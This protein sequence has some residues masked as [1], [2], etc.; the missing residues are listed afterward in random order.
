MANLMGGKKVDAALVGLQRAATADDVWKACVKLMRAA[1]PVYHVLLG[2]PSLGIMPMF[3]RATLAIPDVKRFAEL[4]PLNDVIREQPLTPVSRMSDHFLPD[5]PNWGAFMEECVKPMG[6][7]HAAA[8]LFWN[9]DGVFLGQL[10]LIRTEAQGDFSDA[11]MDLLR[12]LHPHVEAVVHRLLA[13]EER[14]AAH[15]SLEYA[16]GALPLPI[17]VVGWEGGLNFSNA[18]ALDAMSA[19]QSAGSKTARALK[20]TWTLPAEIQAGCEN[21]KRGWE[22]AVLNHDFNGLP[23]NF[24]LT[25]PSVSGF[26]AEIQLVESKAGRALQPSF[27]IHF[28]LPP[29]ENSETA[30][31][32]ARLS[33]LTHAEHEI[34]RLAAA[35]DD[36]AD[37]ARELGIS[38][39][40]VRTH[41]RNVFRKLGITSRSRLVP[42]Y[43]AIK[44]KPG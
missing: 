23:R 26:R 38:L 17:V 12:E 27:A 9:A 30:R 37:I 25:H 39:S 44:Q 18:A 2:L 5:N 14:F 20:P 19:W 4:A 32:L 41:L 24:S 7:R 21:L 33:K 1:M 11:E 8:L 13:L 3:M 29:A 16:I 31:A 40:T 28:Q 42:L 15:L 34:V 43:Q 36:N 22:Q 10:S 35:G 6:W